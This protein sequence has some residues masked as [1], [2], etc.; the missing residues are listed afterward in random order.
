M[1]TPIL[2]G[3]KKVYVRPIRDANNCVMYFIHQTMGAEGC[4]EAAVIATI[5]QKA[6]NAYLKAKPNPPVS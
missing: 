2:S 1:N 5:F 6:L 3:H 4:N